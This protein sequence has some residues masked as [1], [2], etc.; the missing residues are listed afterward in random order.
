MGGGWGC[1][2]VGLLP[3]GRRW[4]LPHV[5]LGPQFPPAALGGLGGAHGFTFIPHAQSEYVGLALESAPS[6]QGEKRDFGTHGMVSW[7]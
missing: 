7:R 3:R 5:L 1:G 4:E 2:P 6:L